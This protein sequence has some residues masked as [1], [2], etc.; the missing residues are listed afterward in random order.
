MMEREPNALRSAC[1]LAA[2]MLVLLGF[3]S[4]CAG[5]TP[6]IA[7]PVVETPHGCTEARERGHEC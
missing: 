3:L 6:F 7:G 5:P 4:G 1:I 2:L